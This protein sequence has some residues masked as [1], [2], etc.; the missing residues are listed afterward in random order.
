MRTLSGLCLLALILTL[1]A[2][3][4]DRQ[5][6]S[7]FFEPGY[8]TGALQGKEP[9]V[10]KG[11][12]PTSEPPKGMKGAAQPQR[13]KHLNHKEWI[14]EDGGDQESAQDLAMVGPPEQP[15]LQPGPAIVAMGAILNCSD[16]E[17]FR[18]EIEQLT[19]IAD[20]YKIKLSVVYALGTRSRALYTP[21]FKL[22]MSQFIR[23]G[24]QIRFVSKLP[25]R[26]KVKHTPTWLIQTEQGEN[27][28]EGFSKLRRLVN[29]RGELVQ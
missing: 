9:K 17:K 5:D 19:T 16:I 27:V 14:R 29:H 6:A 23:G 20:S 7:N 1:P 24:G 11:R 22:T 3:A 18:S 13:E 15:S 10:A 12:K 26:Y 21:E 2:Y 25:D 8:V 4:D 28:L